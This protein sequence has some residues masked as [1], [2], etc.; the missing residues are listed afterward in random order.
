MTRKVRRKA[1]RKRSKLFSTQGNQTQNDLIKDLEKRKFEKIINTVK[2]G[3]S[4]LMTL[5]HDFK[6]SEHVSV[7]NSGTVYY[8]AV[9]E[10]IKDQQKYSDAINKEIESK[11]WI[12]QQFNIDDYDLEN[13][14]ENMLKWDL[15]HQVLRCI[16]RR[17]ANID[18][19]KIRRQQ[20]LKKLMSPAPK[21]SKTLA[22]LKKYG[23][24]Y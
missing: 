13:V 18:V 16:R 17:R 10:F 20:K 4:L 3:G 1:R 14:Y 8:C 7:S 23:V 24:H 19:R 6:E 22:I 5:N 11:E 21:I 9:P 2:K 15:D 12:N